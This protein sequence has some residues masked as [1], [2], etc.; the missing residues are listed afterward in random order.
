MVLHNSRIINYSY[1]VLRGI[2]CPDLLAN[3]TVTNI[4]LGRFGIPPNFL[5]PSLGVM[6]TLEVSDG[7]ADIYSGVQA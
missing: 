7:K 4:S 3:F 2:V 1:H 5:T 6:M